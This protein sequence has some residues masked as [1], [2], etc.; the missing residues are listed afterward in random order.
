MKLS[1]L[2]NYLNHLDRFAPEAAVQTL[3]DHIDPLLYTIENHDLQFP[4]LTRAMIQH[5]AHIQQGIQA[6]SD[7][8]DRLKLEI[9]HSIES[10]E[11]HYLSQSYELYSEG[12]VHDSD[13]H[14]LDR[15]FNLTSDAESYLRARL[16][17]YGDWHHAGMILRPGLETWI[18]DLVSLDPM[19]LVDIRMSLLEPC[20]ADFTPEYQR[21]LRPYVISESTDV[22]MLDHL[23]QQQMGM[24]LVYN[25]FHY[26]P[27]EMMRCFIQ[28]LY[29]LLKPGG[30]LIFTFNDCDRY[31]GVE[32]AERS[33]MCYTPGRLVLAAAEMIG[34]EISHVY[35]I[36][37]AATWVELSKPGE[38]TSQRG[39]QALARIIAKNQQT[40]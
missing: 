16:R 32:L 9:K 30:T 24:I 25:F 5:R 14:I 17:R 19:Y 13:Q 1:A 21:R 8:M 4:A 6:V 11:H 36:D 34:F 40:Q 22:T 12:M 20:Q 7:T 23:P 3:I 15:R 28:E 10:L 18:Q 35:Y 29:Q 31:G 38:L 33:Y 26:K 39:G 37:A 27:L 2:V